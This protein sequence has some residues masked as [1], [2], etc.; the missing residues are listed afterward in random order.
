[1]KRR[2][3]L[4]ASG[5]AMAG[6]AFG[7]V[8]LRAAQMRATISVAPASAGRFLGFG[9]GQAR[10]D[11]HF[12]RLPDAARHAALQRVFGEMPVDWLR[13]WASDDSEWNGASL[14]SGVATTYLD[15]G[16]IAEIAEIAAP[17]LLLAPGHKRLAAMPG[18]AAY[19]DAIAE[20]IL[21]LR[22]AHG[23]A[24]AVTGLANEPHDLTQDFIVEGVKRLRDALDSRG[25]GEVGIVAPESANVNRRTIARM[26]ALRGDPAA[27][28]ALRGLAA[29]SYGMALTSEARELAQGRELWVTE[30]GWG[31]PGRRPNGDG[32]FHAMDAAIVAARFLSD[33]NHG[34]THWLY[35]QGA[36]SAGR[37][38]PNARRTHALVTAS[39]DGRI[40]AEPRC[41]MLTGLANH[42][43]R[44]TSMH[45]CHSS[46]DADMVWTWGAKPTA[47]AAYGEGADGHA[48]MAI[49]NITGIP[50]RGRR[51]RFAPRERL[52]LRLEL[53]R[54][55]ERWSLV[56]RRG[57]EMRELGAVTSDARGECE[58]VVE[59]L[60]V[61]LLTSASRRVIA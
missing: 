18:V 24:V 59:P 7:A 25:L 60:E 40:E 46:V 22:D 45:S 2:E 54:A 11:P 10:N 56:A 17:Q 27:W 31:M 44:D 4:A 35:F 26:A 38:R 16:M 47:L 33:L 5:M 52:E 23:L 19:T 9:M 3:F 14:A 53:P 39:E 30:T 13:L 1:M 55:E 50:S 43:A 12:A 41:A 32:E 8:P 21:R 42:F 15:S 51:A 48:R 28:N 58:V 36:R 34:A 49:A 37:D 20:A 6:T 29:H 61:L 57:G